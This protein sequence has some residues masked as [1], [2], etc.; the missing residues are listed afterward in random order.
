MILLPVFLTRGGRARH[1]RQKDLRFA[2]LWV[3][4]VRSTT[5]KRTTN[6]CE[7]HLKDQ[8][9]RSTTTKRTANAMI[10]TSSGQLQAFYDISEFIIVITQT[11]TKGEKIWASL[12][13]GVR[14]VNEANYECHDFDLERFVR[15]GVDTHDIFLSQNSSSFLLFFII[16]LLLLPIYLSRFVL[17][18]QVG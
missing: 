16:I 1:Q 12:T 5:M 10:L 2:L 9:L 18:S 17:H 13:I 3:R 4:I 7:C 11:A 15:A 14:K 6:L 8:K